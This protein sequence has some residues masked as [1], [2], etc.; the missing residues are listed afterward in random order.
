M[1]VSV[2]TGWAA[3]MSPRFLAR[4]AGLVAVITT[5][6]AFANFVIGNLVDPQDAA[7]TARHI[8]ANEQL[9]RLAAAADVISVLYIVYTL[10]IYYLFRPVNR[11]LALLAALF[12]L[13]GI[14]V[15]MLIPF[16]D[17]AA[18]LVLKDAQPLRAFTQEQLQGMALLFL[19]LRGWIDTLSIV[20]FGIYDII[21]GYL[22]VRSTFLPR[23]FGVWWAIAGVVYLIDVFATILAPDFAALLSPW[24]VIPGLADLVIPVWLLVFG[25]NERRWKEQAIAAEMSLGA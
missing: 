3:K 11:S 2:T 14:A 4:M 17:V 19:Q 21:T 10:L 5:T 1:G 15:G 22:I 12:S 18:L 23:L 20:L 7:A 8:L 25:V 6:A 16:Y 13:V 9:Y 24:I